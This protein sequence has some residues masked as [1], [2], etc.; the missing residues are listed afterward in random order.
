MKM[1][2]CSIGSQKRASTVRFAADV[3]RALGADTTFLGVVPER[4]GV[5]DLRQIL[6]HAAESLSAAG[7][8]AEVIVEAG[9]AEDI[10]LDRMRKGGYDLVGESLLHLLSSGP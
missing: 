10:V 8:P 9:R 5:P 2:V 3:A 7:L 4:N 6:D 1:L